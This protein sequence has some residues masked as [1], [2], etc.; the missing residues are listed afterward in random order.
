M[1]FLEVYITIA[2]YFVMATEVKVTANVIA[3]LSAASAVS[4]PSTPTLHDMFKSYTGDNHCLTNQ[5]LPIYTL[6]CH[7]STVRFT[8]NTGV[9]PKHS[10]SNTD[11]MTK[12]AAQRHIDITGQDIKPAAITRGVTQL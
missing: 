8:N 2:Y 7:L 9:V 4:R 1:T 10:S 12:G 5:T 6:L 11:P 3:S